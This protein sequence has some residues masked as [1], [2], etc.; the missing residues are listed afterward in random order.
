[1]AGPTFRTIP[2][3][4]LIFVEHRESYSTGFGTERSH[5][6]RG[7]HNFDPSQT[8]D[9]RLD[10]LCNRQSPG[11]AHVSRNEPQ[12]GDGIERLW[13][14]SSRGFKSLPPPVQSHVS[15]CTGAYSSSTVDA[16]SMTTQ[17]P[18]ASAASGPVGMTSGY[19]HR[20]SSCLLG[21]AEVDFAC[22]NSF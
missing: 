5:G 7:V 8:Y 9:S 11:Q 19:S 17:A 3:P 22:S 20:Y 18:G 2:A 12:Q 15:G 21:G 14:A 6:H 16:V 13:D 10:R 1:M 4:T